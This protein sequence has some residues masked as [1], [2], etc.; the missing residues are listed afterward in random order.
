[1][2]LFAS[3]VVQCPYGADALHFQAT[4]DLI[5]LIPSSCVMV[6]QFSWIISVKGRNVIVHSIAQCCLYWLFGWGRCWMFQ[7]VKN[8]EASSLLYVKVL[9][10]DQ[11]EQSKCQNLTITKIGIVMALYK[12]SWFWVTV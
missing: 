10:F 2:L 9:T 6:H 3:Q 7:D 11:L 4:I 5:C 1:M 12:T 8:M